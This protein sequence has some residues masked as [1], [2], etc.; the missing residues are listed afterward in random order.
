MRQ[1]H[2]LKRKISATEHGVDHLDV[3][4]TLEEVAEDFTTDHR[5]LVDAT[6]VG[7]TQVVVCEQRRMLD[8]VRAHGA[9]KR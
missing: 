3:G 2:L 5:G 7:A 9:R 8:R 6:A 1:Q 4:I